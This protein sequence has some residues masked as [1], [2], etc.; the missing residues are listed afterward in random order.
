MV[1]GARGSWGRSEVWDLQMSKEELTVDGEWIG[2]VSGHS[3]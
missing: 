3:L 2:K 1:E